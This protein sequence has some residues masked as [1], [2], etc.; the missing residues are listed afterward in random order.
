MI[1]DTVKGAKKKE[2]KSLLGPLKTA[3]SQEEVEQVSQALPSETKKKLYI[4]MEKDS[5]AANL[6]A[7]PKAE[8]A[9]EIQQQKVLQEKAIKDVAQ[10]EKPSAQPPAAVQREVQR[11]SLNTA[12]SEAL[13]YFGPRL[14]AMILGGTDAA[15]VTDKVMRGFEDY[16]RRGLRDEQID[17]QT[18]LR[19]KAIAARAGAPDRK[20]E[21]AE[22][23]LQMDIQ[24]AQEER[25]E[26]RRKRESETQ[27][28]QEQAQSVVDELNVSLNRM[29]ESLGYLK[30]GGLTGTFDAGVL[31]AFE[32]RSGSPKERG[33]LLLEKLGLDEKLL[34]TKEMKGAISDREFKELGA[35]IP[36]MSDDESIWID[37]INE[38]K[39]IIEKAIKNISKK[40]PG[41]SESV[42]PSRARLEELRAKQRARNA[43]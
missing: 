9:R 3:V 5:T 8:I 7:N 41:Q 39:P 13:Q 16:Q 14:G 28:E 20:E 18:K 12:F 40:I 15:E 6:Q 30:E 27:K 29:T 2:K 38:K 36:Q 21:R 23:K 34:R 43:R 4:E 19:E 22:I 32:R 37:W 35:G 24:K 25:E 17:E 33:R 31:R 26:R 11:Q 1:G 10:A 42:S